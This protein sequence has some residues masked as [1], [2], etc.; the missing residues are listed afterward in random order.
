M[1]GKGY[2]YFKAFEEMVDYALKSARL[3]QEFV[4]AYDPAETFFRL[5]Q[6]HGV[7]HN[8]DS[9]KHE[10]MNNLA[11]EFI[12][13]IERE[14][15]IELAGELDDVVD[16]I[17]EIFQKMYIFDVKEVS[18]VAG[19]F[20]GIILSC[21]EALKEAMREFSNFKKSKNIKDRLI[22]INTY[23]EDGDALYIKVVRSMFTAHD[24]TVDLLRW[25][26]T[27]DAF[28][29]CCDACEHVAVTMEGIIMK[30]S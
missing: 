16:G 26:E 13:P 11:R 22:E 5:E 20:T 12:P 25:I 7:E 29:R 14:D 27:V 23:E 8:A 30:N 17:E 2:D 28:E 10:I 21:C 4:R 19:Q 6:A 9:K 24:N 1:K 3:L 18:E 15:I